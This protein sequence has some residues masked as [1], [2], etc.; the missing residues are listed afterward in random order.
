[1]SAWRS[2]ASWAA[3]GL[4]G[5]D[6]WKPDEAYTFGSVYEIAQ[7]NQWLIPML[8]GEPFLEKPP[9]FVATAAFF[10][11]LLRDFL[12]LHDG[13]RVA[14]MFY[15]LLTLFFIGR[16]GRELN[17]KGFGWLPA[18]L[19]V[20]A[21]GMTENAHRLL[22]DNALLCGLAMG[23]Y[24][25]ALAPRRP[26][27]AGFWLGTGAGIAFM[28]KGLIGPTLLALTAILL[29]VLPHWRQWSYFRT[30]V[31]ALTPRCRGC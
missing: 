7:S 30:F 29:P 8:A 25:M 10:A 5:H 21:I 28:A 3:L 31:V 26:Y 6:P 11:Q 17:G 18:L 14:T 1:M 27:W 2:S 22:V 19:L 20:G 9:L 12:P 24:G 4:F 15:V 16:A 23:L 13:A